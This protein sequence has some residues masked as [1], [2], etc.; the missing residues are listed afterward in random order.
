MKALIGALS[1][2]RYEVM[3]NKPAAPLRDARSDT[4]EWN[5]ELERQK[6]RHNGEE[7]KW[8]DSAWLWMECYLYRRIQEAISMR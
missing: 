5:K 7:L 4:S 8:F 2:L 6:E 3:T 1:Q